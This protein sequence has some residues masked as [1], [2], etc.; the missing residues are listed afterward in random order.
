MVSAPLDW[1][2]C[3]AVESIP[4]KVAGAWL[5]KGTRTPLARMGP[6][7]EWRITRI[8]RGRRV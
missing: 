3:P 2:Q 6:A 7:Y 5:F 8:F 1:S 4:S